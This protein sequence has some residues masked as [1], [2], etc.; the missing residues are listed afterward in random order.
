MENTKLKMDM[1]NGPIWNKLIQYALPVAATGILEQLFNASDLAVVGNF[2]GEAKTVAVAAVGANSPIVGLL[3]N[4]FIGIALGANVVIANAIGKKDEKTIHKAVHTAV[5]TA[6]AGGVLVVVLGEFLIGYLLQMLNVPEDVF[7]YALLY[8]RIYLLGMPVILLYNFEAAIFRSVGETK[9]PLKALAVSGVLNVVLNLIFV[10]VF[11]MTVN[12]VAIA[13]VLSN[14]VS[15][16]LLLI[17]LIRTDSVIRIRRQ[18]LAF[19]TGVFEKI[20]RI[21]LPA[22]V[23]SA[24]FAV[25]NIVIQSAI[26]SLGTVVIAASSAAFNIEIFVYDILN[27]FSQAC[28][29]FTGQ[30]YGAGQLKRCRKVLIL[31]ILEDAVATISGII[32]VLIFGKT[33]LSVFNNDPQ[34]IEIGY[35]RLLMVFSAYTFSMLY[36]NMSGYLRGFGISLAPAVL[37]TIG[38]CGVRLL[39]IFTVFP[40]HRT[41]TAIMMAYPLSLSVTAVLIFIALMVYRPSRKF[42]VKER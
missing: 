7:P 13:T 1:I 4:F 3:L 6:V 38:V 27:S 15:S 42:N 9:T 16:I 20:I 28:T 30:N 35:T 29:T 26:N 19:D 32:L 17:K 40:M 21:G 24:V 25:A 8:I 31:C 12:G 22:G 11:K 41:F 18:E 2:T 10:I 34:V 36:E 39:W 5:I 33:L 14:T 37:T 23:Q